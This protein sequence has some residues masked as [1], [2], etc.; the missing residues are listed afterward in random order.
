MEGNV[1]FDWADVCDSAPLARRLVVLAVL[2]I[3]AAERCSAYSVLTHEAIIDSLWDSHIRPL[4]MRRF[5]DATASDIRKAHAYVYGGSLVQDMGYAPFSSRL[6][7]DLTHYVRSGALVETFIADSQTLNEYAFALGTLA[8]YAADITG[9]PAIN[10]IVPEIY[11]KLR[12]KFG[13]VVTYEDHPADHLKTEFALD[14]I[15]VSRGLYAP[16]DYH[17]FIGFEVEKASLERA[18]AKTYGIEL[19]D[20]F[21]SEDLAIG[22]YRF[23]AGT[24]IPKA[25]KVAWNSKRKDLEKLSASVTRSKFVYALPAKQYRK[26]WGDKYQR[27]GFLARCMAVVFR[28]VPT[29]G[30]FKALGFRPMPPTGEQMFLKSFDATVE[31]YGSLLTE[32]RHGTLKLQDYNLDTGVLTHPGDYRLADQAYSTLVDKLAE[33]NFATAS[34]ELRANI[35][36]FFGR[37][38]AAS[39]PAKTAAQL[40][41]LRQAAPTQTATALQ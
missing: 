22:T 28:L 26:E 5:P 35:Q 1:H 24:L 31:R 2:L 34:D 29:F 41:E 16:E 33:K 12:A 18:F 17:D 11:P 27:P 32:V 19:K 40:Q 30:P 23:A 10:R 4:L 39:I 25:T 14:V 36:E 7:S 37:M 3:P 6:M 38:Q 13:A 8:H 20:I 21:L 9:H 15:Q